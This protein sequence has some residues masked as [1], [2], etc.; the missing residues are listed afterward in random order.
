[1]NGGRIMKRKLIF[2]LA[3]LVI[4]AAVFA[5]GCVFNMFSKDGPNTATIKLEGNPT[6]GYNWIYSLVPDGIIKET[7]RDY[8][9][10]SNFFNK[11]GVGG[12]FI[13]KFESVAPGEAELVFQY[14]REWENKPPL[15]IEAYKVI[16]DEGL[17]L[18]LEEIDKDQITSVVFTQ[19]TIK[20][21]G[22][23]SGGI[24]WRYTIEPDGIIDEPLVTY[25]EN[26][27]DADGGDVTYF[28]NFNPL[29]PGEATI[30][31][32]AYCEWMDNPPSETIVYLATVDEDM[33]MTLTRLD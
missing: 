15:I 4:F 20:L 18:T 13:F 21:T 7:S 6:T 19:Q 22:N 8:K 16:V 2:V 26:N 14:L 28:F 12:T 9:Q 11:N 1:M 3:V 10:D 5:G 30:T 32:E 25:K 29:A 33:K 23:P 17:N 31:F 24:S 27:P